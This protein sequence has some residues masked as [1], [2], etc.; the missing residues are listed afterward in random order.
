MTIVHQIMRSPHKGHSHSRRRAPVVNLPPA[1]AD[2]RLFKAGEAVPASGVY[3]V[4]HSAHR[5]SHEVSMVAGE[6]FPKCRTCNDSV[7][8][9]LIVA[10]GPQQI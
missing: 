2:V 1:A 9:Q 7:A 8:Y 5:P 10:E 6:T 4:L 3:R